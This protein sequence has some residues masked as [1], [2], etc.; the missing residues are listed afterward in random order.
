MGSGTAIVGP[1]PKVGEYQYPVGAW[2]DDEFILR[3]G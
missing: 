1:H 3:R 2:M